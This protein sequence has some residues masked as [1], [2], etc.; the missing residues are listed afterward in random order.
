MAVLPPLAAGSML[1]ALCLASWAAQ[2][3]RSFSRSRLAELCEKRN[4]SE[5]FSS[6]LKEHER[7][8]RNFVG[9]TL[10]LAAGSSVLI[11][12]WLGF[13]KEWDLGDAWTQTMIVFRWAT[14]LIAILLFGGLI[15]WT[16]S[17]VAGEW[18]LF[19][20]WPCMLAIGKVMTPFRI[21]ADRFDRIVHRIV[22]HP[23]PDPSNP[24]SIIADELKSMVD[25]GQ[26]EGVIESGA[27]SMIGKVM[28]LGDEDVSSIMTPRTEMVVLSADAS[29]EQARQA[30]AEGGHSRLP[31]IKD[32]I[33]DI[34]G[35]LYA[36]DLLQN[37]NGQDG[38][39]SIRT[40]LREPVF[41]PENTGIN[42]LL[43]QMQKGGVHIVV[44]V[45]EYGGVAGLATLEDV[46]EEIVGDILDEY[47]D[48]ERE[49]ESVVRVDEKTLDIEAKMHIDDINEQFDLGLPEDGDF[50]TLG[51]FVYDQ[52]GKVPS[53]GEEFT[54]ND[55]NVSILDADPRRVLN[56]RIRDERS[57]VPT[58]GRA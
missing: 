2:S 23:D 48:E 33:D 44:V 47:D 3:L 1:L 39:H 29:Y 46:L 19:Q 20:T 27:G 53:A 24:A 56:V 40:L 17:R 50:D 11:S 57:S 42:S 22:G 58:N 43:E 34:V 14:L 37:L 31:A 35:I 25:E 28:E 12:Q 10:L 54:W 18:Y 26:R 55:L 7:I 45:D 32:S 21:V 15:P 6:I 38:E 4:R 30:F 49:A 8:E 51:G 5:R 52:L 36:K 9:I 16:L 13:S 41:V